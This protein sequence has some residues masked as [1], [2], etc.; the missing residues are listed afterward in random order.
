VSTARRAVLNHA[1]LFLLSLLVGGLQ[2]ATFAVDTSKPA[3]SLNESDLIQLVGHTH[4]FATAKYDQGAVAD[5]LR[6]DHMFVVLGRSAEQQ[7]A[8]ERLSRELHD[9]RSANYHKWLCG[10]LCGTYS[11][12][13]GRP[14]AIASSYFAAGDKEHGFS[15]LERAFNERDDSLE[16]IKTDLFIAQFRSDA[17]YPELLR[18]MGLPQ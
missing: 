16:G 4:P 14:T 1:W 15:W 7:Q 3:G 10:K 18:R 9:P 13:R 11:K 5:T 8:L 6:M 12:N 2:R 17:R